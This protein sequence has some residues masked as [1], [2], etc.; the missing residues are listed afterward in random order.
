MRLLEAKQQ[1]Y[2]AE[3]QVLRQTINN[4]N[5]T[6]MVLAMPTEGFYKGYKTHFKGPSLYVEKMP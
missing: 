3:L 2:G 1:K 6:T 4:T 5:S